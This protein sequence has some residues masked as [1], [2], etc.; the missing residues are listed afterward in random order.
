MPR[1]RAPFTRAEIARARAV[2]EKGEPGIVV[3]LRRGNSILRV[4][5]A[6]ESGE[7]KPAPLE[8]DREFRL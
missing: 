8:R 5:R 6:V 2:V 4:S 1:R 3:E 7:K